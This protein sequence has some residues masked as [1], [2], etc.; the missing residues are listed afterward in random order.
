MAVTFLI[1]IVFVSLF[2]SM[3]ADDAANSTCFSTTQLERERAHKFWDLYDIRMAVV[4]TLAVL[5][6]AV[7]CCGICLLLTSFYI[8]SEH[9]SVENISYTQNKL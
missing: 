7:T 8:E 9:P 5:G 2:G 3:F 6:V 1:Q 4:V